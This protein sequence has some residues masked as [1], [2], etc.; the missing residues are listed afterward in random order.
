MLNDMFAVP[1][2]FAIDRLVSPLLHRSTPSWREIIRLLSKEHADSLRP[3]LTARSYFRERA[4]S[5]TGRRPWQVPSDGGAEE[6]WPRAT[7]SPHHAERLPLRT[8]V[9]GNCDG[10]R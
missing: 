3:A 1:N 10:A 9:S 8:N 2:A 4:K 7:Q 5:R 6:F